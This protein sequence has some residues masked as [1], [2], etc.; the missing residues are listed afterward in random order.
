[1]R[2]KVLLLRKEEVAKQRIALQSNQ[3]QRLQRE[4]KRKPN[5]VMIRNPVQKMMHL[6]INPDQMQNPMPNQMRKKR[7]VMNQLRKRIAQAEQIE[8]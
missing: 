6:M 2:A 7:K 5:L 8:V 1:M 4:R 3:R